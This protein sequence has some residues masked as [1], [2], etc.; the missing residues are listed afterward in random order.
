MTEQSAHSQV[1][2]FKPVCLQ[3]NQFILITAAIVSRTKT[4][5]PFQRL[6]AYISLFCPSLL[7]V[8]FL[9]EMPRDLSRLYIMATLSLPFTVLGRLR[10]DNILLG[11]GEKN[12][13]GRQASKI[14]D[15]HKTNTEMLNVTCVTHK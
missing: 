11:C 13:T 3:Q 2:L 7:Q 12:S 10:Y 8:T 9:T 14:T 4:C 1:S 15:A 5:N 6:L